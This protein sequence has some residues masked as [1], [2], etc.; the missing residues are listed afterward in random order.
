MPEGIRTN[1]RHACP[2]LDRLTDNIAGQEALFYSVADW[3]HRCS[4]ILREA[5]LLQLQ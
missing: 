2:A 5:N 1:G 4:L 3:Q